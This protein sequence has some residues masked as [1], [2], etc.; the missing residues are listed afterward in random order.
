MKWFSCSPI[1]CSLRW[2]GSLVLLLSCRGQFLRMLCL[3]PICLPIWA[4][5]G[6][7]S[8][9]GSLLSMRVFRRLVWWWFRCGWWCLTCWSC[10]RC[11]SRRWAAWWIFWGRWCSRLAWSICSIGCSRWRG[12]FRLWFVWA[13]SFRRTRCWSCNSNDAGRNAATVRTTVRSVQAG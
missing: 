5:C 11:L 4:V 1:R 6:L 3:V 7:S 8:R 10:A 12:W 13:S 9:P 2:W